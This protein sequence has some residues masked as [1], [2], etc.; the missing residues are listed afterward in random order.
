M[1]HNEFVLL[2]GV[3]MLTHTMPDI[4]KAILE[5][6]ER[7]EITAYK[8]AQMLKGKRKGRKDVPPPTLYQ[9]LRGDN[10]INSD[11]LGLIF[12]ALGM[13]VNRKG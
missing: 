12:D 7:Q 13:D 11:D 9:F 4:R 1:S 8:L 2:K 6:M 5:E 3:T 10:P